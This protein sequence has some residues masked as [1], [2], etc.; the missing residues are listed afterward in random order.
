MTLVLTA[1]L[2]GEPLPQSREISVHKQLTVSFNMISDGFE[3]T[4]HI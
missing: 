2:R 1:V 3:Q 4:R